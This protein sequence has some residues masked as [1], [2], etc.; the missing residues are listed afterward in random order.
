[1]TKSKKKRESAPSAR[2]II[3][4]P[5]KTSAPLAVKNKPTHTMKKKKTKTTGKNLSM[6]NPF[7]TMTKKGSF[8]STNFKKTKKMSLKTTKKKNAPTTLTTILATSTTM[9][10]TTKT[11]TK[12]T[13]TILRTDVA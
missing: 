4:N 7:K 1:M 11:K 6:T 10:M 13:M 9:T 12:K 5:T 2:S 3:S 8:R